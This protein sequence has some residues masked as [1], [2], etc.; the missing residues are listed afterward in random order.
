MNFLLV[1]YFAVAVVMSMFYNVVPLNAQQFPYQPDHDNAK[2]VCTIN[3]KVYYGIDC[4]CYSSD[5]G[6]TFITVTIVTLLISFFISGC[7]WACIF[8]CCKCVMGS[9][10]EGDFGVGSIRS[11]MRSTHA[12]RRRPDDTQI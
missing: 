7:I 1:S 3:G 11:S 4:W 9:K 8:A 12:M 10:D 5:V 6:T 2:G